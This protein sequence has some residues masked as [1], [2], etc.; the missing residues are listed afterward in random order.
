MRK[1]LSFEFWDTLK[2]K[3]DGMWN[4]K[5]K[6]K[7]KRDKRGER[8]RDKKNMEINVGERMRE[9]KMEKKKKW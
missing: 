7:K 2:R 8:E 3:K 1:N 6:E 9:T 4:E 5:K